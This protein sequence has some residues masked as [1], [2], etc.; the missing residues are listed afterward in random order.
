MQNKNCYVRV[1]V[2]QCFTT[3][4]EN[5]KKGI[6]GLKSVVSDCL[7]SYYQITFQ[8]GQCTPHYK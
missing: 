3:V 7:T 5:P 1:L 8:K 6:A 4:G 2:I